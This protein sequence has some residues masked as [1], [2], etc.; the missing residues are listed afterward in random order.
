MSCRSTVQHLT[1]GFVLHA[2]AHDL[3]FALEHFATIAEDLKRWTVCRP[4]FAEL[5]VAKARRLVE[6]S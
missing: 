3:E 5:Q 6:A 4:L 1:T 2:A